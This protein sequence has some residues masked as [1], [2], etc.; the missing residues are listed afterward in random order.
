MNIQTEKNFATSRWERVSY[1]N[2][3]LGQNLAFIIVTSFLSVYYTTTLGISAAVVG[4]ILLLARV[5]DAL[6]DPVLATIIE[7]SNLRGG[8]F[9]PWIKLASFTVPILT[10]L[11]FGFEHQLLNAALGLRITYAA[12]TY[13]LWG[14]IFAASDAPSYALATVMTPYPEERNKLLSFL[15]INSMVG[16]LLG[17]IG[18]PIVLNATNNNY[19]ITILI[20]SVITFVFMYMARF[21]KERVKQEDR[22]SPSVKQI[23][24]SVVRN[25]YLVAI[26]GLSIISWGTN[27][28]QAIAPYIGSDIYKDENVT[29]LILGVGLLPILLVAP[30]IPALIRKFGKIHLLGFSF[31]ANIV[32]SLII[33]FVGPHNLNLFLALSFV[34]AALSAPPMII[35]SLFFA[36]CM[37]YDCYKNGTRFEAATFAMQTLTS[38]IS[39]AISGGLGLW[40]LAA[41]GFKESIAGQ[42]VV[43]T[44]HTLDG[45]WAI[46]NL[47]PAVGCL[48]GLF[49]LYKFYDLTEEKVKMMVD[50]NMKR[51]RIG[52]SSDVIQSSSNFK[53]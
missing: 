29:S 16:I 19:M 35:Y 46:Y 5:W 13:L 21:T 9:K 37:E 43:Q 33:H 2:Y 18:F 41:V 12:V 52:Q 26:I 32:L 36:D 25:K 53:A 23:L 10:V 40:L 17:V 27:F 34:R 22:P 1:Y 20:F 28:A 15:Q 24:G 11:C 39:L 4:T 6:V 31:V 7:K 49:I 44:Q 50:E 14:T 45:M 3:Y 38:K 48:L 30:F 8:K 51:A 42:T 47:G